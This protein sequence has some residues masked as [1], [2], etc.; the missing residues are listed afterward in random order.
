MF[1]IG[2]RYNPYGPSPH[3]N[4]KSELMLSMLKKSLLT[5]PVRV[6]VIVMAVL[7]TNC[8]LV[9]AGPQTNT[10]PS[11]CCIESLRLVPIVLKLFCTT[12]LCHVRDMVMS[13]LKRK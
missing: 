9:E 4:N 8:I 13:V 11:R 2:M 3:A 5:D 10:P 1:G 7:S 12:E 6:V